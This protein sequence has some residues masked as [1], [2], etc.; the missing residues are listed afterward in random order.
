MQ[1]RYVEDLVSH[2]DP[3]S[4]VVSREA[5]GKALTGEQAGGVILVGCSPENLGGVL[6]L[7]T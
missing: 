7:S 4:C 5:V 1:V 3:E 6:W 2:D